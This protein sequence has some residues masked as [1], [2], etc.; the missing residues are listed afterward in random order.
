MS[1]KR[2]AFSVVAVVCVAI[3]L[4]IS[5]GGQAEPARTE[6]PGATSA[7]ILSGAE[8][9]QDR[10]ARC[11]GL[12]IVEAENQSQAEWEATVEQMR[13]KG[14]TLTDAEAKTLVEYLALNYGP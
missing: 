3:L 7:P 5:C 14:T 8:L 10:C 1:K 9:L 13:Q 11:H 6:A 12:D 4:G 2:A